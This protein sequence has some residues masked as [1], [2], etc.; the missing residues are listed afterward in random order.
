MLLKQDP[1]SIALYGLESA[2][3]IA[4]PIT[5]RMVIESIQMKGNLY[6]QGILNKRENCRKNFCPVIAYLAPPGLP[7]ALSFLVLGSQATLIPLSYNLTM[8]DITDSLQYVSDIIIVDS[9]LLVTSF[10]NSV[11]DACS[12]VAEA[13]ALTVHEAKTIMHGDSPITSC[14]AFLKAGVKSFSPLN[15]DGDIENIGIEESAVNNEDQ[16]H[17]HEF[18]VAGSNDT[19][20]LLRTSGTTS[21]SKLVPLTNQNV[22]ANAN[23]IAEGLC[24]SRHD[25]ALNAMPLFHIGGLSANLLAPLSVGGATILLPNFNVVEFVDIIEHGRRSIERVL[26]EKDDNS[27]LRFDSFYTCTT[28]TRHQGDHGCSSTCTTRIVGLPRSGRI[29]KTIAA[30]KGVIRPTWYHAVPTMHATIVEFLSSRNERIS[31]GLRFIRSGAANLPIKTAH[32][33]HEIFGVRVVPSYSMTEQMPICQAP[34]DYVDLNYKI[35]SVG[36]PLAVTVGI[37]DASNTLCHLP[38]TTTE[39]N[40]TDSTVNNSV[41]T[42]EICCSGHL[43]FEGYMSNEAANVASFFTTASGHTFFRSGDVGYLD[44]DG[45]LFLTGRSKEMIKRGGEQVSPFEVEEEILRICPFVK[46]A[47]CF[48][49]PNDLMGEQVGLAIV[50]IDPSMQPYSSSSKAKCTRLIRDILREQSALSVAKYPEHVITVK[51]EEELVKNATGKFVRVGLAKHLRCKS[52]DYDDEEFKLGNAVTTELMATAAENSIDSRV[53]PALKGVAFCLAFYVCWNHLY[54]QTAKP[55][56]SRTWF[57]HEAMFFWLGGFNLASGNVTS[58][59]NWRAFKNFYWRTFSS[60]LPIYWLSLVFVVL[61]FLVA[62]N[63]S[64][65][66]DSFEYGRQAQCQATPVASNWYVSFLLTVVLYILTLQVWVFFTPFTWFLH[67]YSWF[68]SVYTSLVM[69]FPL[70]QNHSSNMFPDAKR[71]PEDPLTLF[72]HFAQ[73]MMLWIALWAIFSASLLILYFYSLH[74]HVAVETINWWILG[75]YML[76]FRWLSSFA[77]GASSFHLFRLTRPDRYYFYLPQY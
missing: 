53:S 44:K 58:F 41:S 35:G 7:S 29:K 67:W 19:I 60:L 55:N 12:S 43:V 6:Q 32:K 3:E 56:S 68:L 45:Y 73:K 63:P 40:N 64:T 15:S 59:A 8:D 75:L 16:Y 13:G 54:T 76:P 5:Y 9:H 65:Y 46:I 10:L 49:V 61:T 74:G 18:H 72:Y 25:V 20:L 71:I 42:G 11:R 4:L 48:G 77:F 70:I 1:S 39:E 36:R 52:S 50:L 38:E 47:L 31:H 51:S 23:I 22:V 21:K 2:N 66:L 17:H 37:F 27:S 24:I 62:C 28:P 26:L 57:H 30:D 69:I 14:F 33:L 34:I